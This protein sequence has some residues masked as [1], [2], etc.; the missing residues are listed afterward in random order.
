[1]EIPASLVAFI[2]TCKPLAAERDHHS[3]SELLEKLLAEPD[4][5][6]EVP[7]FLNV[8]PSPL[9]WT[10]GGEHVC[11]KSDELTVMV[12][13]TLP[14]VLQP[15]HD[16]EMHAI[17]GVFEGCEEQRFFARGDQGVTQAAGRT[18]HAG[19]VMVLG[20]RAIHAISSPAG[21]PARAV[22][23]YFGDIY[24]VERSLFNPETLEEC[25]FTAET[26]DDFCRA[27]K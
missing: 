8:E 7:P 5:A 23:V 11:Y 24:D 10:L 26:Y 25:R 17:I 2:E 6:T 12:L 13:D 20:E 21:Q 9:G 27:D 16:H 4:F 14:G 22:H 3:I 18:L 19:D 15:P 1:M